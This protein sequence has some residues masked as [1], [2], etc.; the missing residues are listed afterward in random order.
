[1]EKEK[2]RNLSSHCN[3]NSICEKLQEKKNRKGK[4]EK[5]KQ[6]RAKTKIS[7]TPDGK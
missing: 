3:H 2:A 5:R 6:Q 7:G 4:T 1:M